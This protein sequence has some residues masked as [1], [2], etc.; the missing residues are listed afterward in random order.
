MN[1]LDGKTVLITGA[2][3]G[4]GLEAAK[5]LASCRCRIILNFAHN[6][7]DARNALS[8]LHE[9]GADAE[10]HR[11]DVSDGEDVEA[12]FLNLAEC[13]GNVDVLINC[14]GVSPEH[15]SCGETED[16][17][18]DRCFSVKV[19]GAL[20]CTQS[21][22]RNFRGNSEGLVINVT[23]QE[24]HDLVSDFAGDCLKKLTE[25]FTEKNIRFI[26]TAHCFELP[27]NL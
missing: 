7:A 21:F 1:N 10:L 17:W 22:I 27:E 6:S 25:K 2:T 23:G 13:Y 8:L 11:A 15:R 16:E 12:M 24:T 19:K 9:L 26:Q 18:F 14:A 3:R 5:K 20:L 4:A